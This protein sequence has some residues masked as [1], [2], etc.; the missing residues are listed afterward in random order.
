[1][2]LHHVA[3][4]TAGI[5]A[6]KQGLDID[7]E[8]RPLKQSLSWNVVPSSELGRVI[9]RSVGTFCVCVGCDTLVLGGQQP[10]QSFESVFSHGQ[11]EPQP[12]ALHAAI[13]GLCPAADGFRPAERLFNLLSMPL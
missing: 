11:D 4:G 7:H 3:P 6:L 5:F 13:H 10:G 2:H 8:N 9:T 1:M 12:D